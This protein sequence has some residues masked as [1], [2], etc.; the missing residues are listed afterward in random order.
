MIKPHLL[1]WG[2]GTL[3]LLSGG[4]TCANQVKGTTDAPFKWTREE[5]TDRTFIKD[6]HPPL[7]TKVI[8]GEETE[9]LNEEDVK[10]TT[11]KTESQP[12]RK[13]HFRGFPHRLNFDGMY[14]LQHPST[15]L[16]PQF[17]RFVN[18]GLLLLGFCNPCEAKDEMEE[19]AWVAS[20][21]HTDSIGLDDG[22]LTVKT[23]SFGRR[24]GVFWFTE[25]KR[26]QYTGQIYP[27][28]IILYNK[29]KKD[30]IKASNS[31]SQYRYTYVF[32][33]WPESR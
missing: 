29:E 20:W 5:P 1:V 3:F 11:S 17:L 19:A 15:D 6:Q 16:V 32:V 13:R 25:G 10:K 21:L 12:V 18:R 31:D 7:N 4:E 8:T 28:H 14:K 30:K 27:T 9:G 26:T 24:E 2:M 33:P 22:T 23:A